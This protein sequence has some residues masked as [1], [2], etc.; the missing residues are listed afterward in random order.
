M[1]PRTWSAAG[2]PVGYVAGY[3]VRF[4]ARNVAFRRR[5]R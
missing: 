4:S 2:Y 3:H 1:T 5:F